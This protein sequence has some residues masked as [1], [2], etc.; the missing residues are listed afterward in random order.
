MYVVEVTT[1]KTVFVN[2]K[3]EETAK[4]TA[5]MRASAEEADSCDAAVIDQ[6]NDDWGESV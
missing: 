3:D 2:A 6:Y 1:K 5:C 4:Y